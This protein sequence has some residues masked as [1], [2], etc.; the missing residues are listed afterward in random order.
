MRQRYKD[1]LVV[2][3]QEA[4]VYLLSSNSFTMTLFGIVMA[5]SQGSY[6]ISERGLMM[7]N[8]TCAAL[9]SR[10]L[11]AA[12][13]STNSVTKIKPNTPH[14]AYHVTRP[15]VR[16]TCMYMVRLY[17]ARTDRDE[18]LRNRTNTS[19]YEAVHKLR[20]Q[21]RGPKGALGHK[22]GDERAQGA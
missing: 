17:E 20:P 13:E 14:S 7:L 18:L 12:T 16:L 9:L 11:S 2:G 6:A 15:S 21:G 22:C 1:D 4:F 3:L 8:A 19:I 5:L 10:A